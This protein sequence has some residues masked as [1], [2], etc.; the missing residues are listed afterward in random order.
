MSLGPFNDSFVT[1]R[2]HSDASVASKGFRLLVTRAPHDCSDGRVAIR[3]GETGILSPPGMATNRILHSADCQWLLS[4]PP[5]HRVQVD[6]DDNS[7]NLYDTANG[8]P[9]TL[10]PQLST[11]FPSSLTPLG[12][13]VE[14]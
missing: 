2:F 1:I 14:L 11:L 9:I 3:E 6:V 7:F 10:P 5:G 12:A 4:A 13:A 8:Y